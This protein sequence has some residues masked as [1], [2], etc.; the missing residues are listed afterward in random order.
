[1]TQEISENYQ[2]TKLQ[3]VFVFP[4]PDVISRSYK[5]LSKFYFPQIIVN[6]SLGFIELI[7]T[8]KA[9]VSA[10]TNFMSMLWPYATQH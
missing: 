5:I 4:L 10:N 8:E 2:Q 1:M 9:P 6:V 3:S 7:F